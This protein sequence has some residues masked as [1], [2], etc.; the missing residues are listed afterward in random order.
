MI[1]TDHKKIVTNLNFQT[2][3]EMTPKI[4]SVRTFFFIL[5]LLN[6]LIFMNQTLGIILMSFTNITGTNKFK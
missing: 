5:K 3:F 4:I 1:I 2:R 6:F